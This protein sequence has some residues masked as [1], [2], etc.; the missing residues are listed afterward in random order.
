MDADLVDVGRLVAAV[1][2]RQRMCAEKRGP[3]ADAEFLA[4]APCDL[5]HLAF[6]VQIQAIARFDFQ[7]SD[8]V[9]EQRACARQR[10]GEQRFGT[11]GAGL[12][13]GGID[14]AAGAG[15]LFVARAVEALL[16]FL[17]AVAGEDEVSVA[18]DQA[19]GDPR[20]LQRFDLAREGFRRAGQFGARPGERDEPVLPG[21]CGIIDAPIG[22][23]I[24]GQRG[25]PAIQ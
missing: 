12:A 22:V 7:R 18:V 24:V 21:D 23:S 6:A 2:G 8:A 9:G 15:D 4:D 11:R 19:R 14:A 20:A 5:E 1:F 13:Y 16:E 3:H 17:R 25:Q 10:L